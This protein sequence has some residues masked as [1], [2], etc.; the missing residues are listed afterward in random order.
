VTL[1]LLAL[2]ILQPPSEGPSAPEG[3]TPPR[4]VEGSI[5][6]VDYPAA[7]IR[8]NEQG[9]TAVELVVDKGGRIAT[10]D[11]VGSSGSAILDATTCSVIAQR[12]RYEPARDAAGRAVTARVRR[13]V[14]WR[15]PSDVPALES[16]LPTFSSGEMRLGVASDPLG[17]KCSIETVGET[18]LQ[19]AETVCP[20]TNRV[21]HAEL[22]GNPAATMQVTAVIPEGSQRE[23][24]L[25]RGTLLGRSAA[26]IEIDSAGRLINCREEEVSGPQLTRAGFCARF[27][28]LPAFRP[29]A[30]GEGHRARVEVEVYRL[31]APEV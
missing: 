6:D 16:F 23:R 4:Q 5:S 30:D 11:V 26:A 2:T 25:V 1:F 3:A 10:C 14:T 8:A 7:A 24:G 18:F 15:F 27:G 13:R 29:P 17:V 21:P 28:Q 19:I 9:T 31:G 22:V 20:T 12:F